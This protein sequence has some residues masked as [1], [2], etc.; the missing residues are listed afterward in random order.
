[1]TDLDDAP[2][3]TALP[4]PCSLA[5]ESAVQLKPLLSFMLLQAGLFAGCTGSGLLDSDGDGSPDA[6]DCAPDDPARYPTATDPFGND[7]DENCDGVDGTDADGDGYPA[8][9]DIDCNDLSASVNPGAAENCDNGGD[10]DCDGLI[11][12]ADPDCGGDDDDSAGGDDDDS[13][14]DDDAVDDDDDAT[15]DDDDTATLCNS[16]TTAQGIDLVHL[17]SGTFEMGCTA[18]QSNCGAD[19]DQHTVTLTNDFLLGRFEVTQGQWTAMM[20]PNPNPSYFGPNGSGA[21]CGTDC[22]VDSVNW[23]EALAFANALSSAAIPALDECYTLIGCDSNAPGTDME[24]TEVTINSADGTVYSCEGYRLPT[25]AE[26]EYAARGG[27]DLL[28]SGSDTMSDVGFYSSNSGATTHVVGT[29]PQANAFGLWDMSGNVWEWT[30]DGYD[31]GYYSSSPG[32]DPAG[33][34]GPGT[35][36]VSRGGSWGDGAADVRVAV[37]FD[38]TP[39]DAYVAQGFRLA[40]TVP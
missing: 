23:W 19:E 7:V 14:D 8:D 27:E 35:H 30:Q 4:A 6:E 3:N 40:R 37:R 5:G 36:R 13:A 9:D 33:P 25:E 16:V 32:T 2:P 26:W 31:S 21:D 34:T 1:M 18:G 15:S 10:E 28:Y 38:I 11:D 17:C 12:A 24:C 22:P 39:G 29:A 20:S